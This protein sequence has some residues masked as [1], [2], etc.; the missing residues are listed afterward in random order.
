MR[1]MA[2]MIILIMMT[3]T[4]AGCF[5]EDVDPYKDKIDQLETD[6]AILESENN[7]LLE[8]VNALES[9]I[10]TLHLEQQLLEAE[11]NSSEIQIENLE[12]E[13]QLLESEKNFFEAKIENLEA[14]KQLLESEKNSS[15]IQIENLEAE[16]QLLALQIVNL[17]A[18]ITN[19]TDQIL[20]LEVDIEALSIELENSWAEGF[21]AGY[22]QAGDGVS[23]LDVIIER[24]SLKCGV[25]DSQRGMGFMDSNGVRSG[26]DISYCRA[27]AAAIGLDPD[28]DIEYVDVTAS[29]RF[30]TLE[31][32]TIDVLIRTT[33]RTTSRDAGLNVDF[34][35]TNF[36]DGIA[37]MVSEDYNYGSINTLSGITICV[38]NG[39]SIE[40]LIN[41][42]FSS[43]G[44]S[45]SVVDITNPTDATNKF[46]Q[47]QC[48][49]L[50][51]DRSSLAA[52]W[53]DETD[54]STE[55]WWSWITPEV[56]S[57]E[58]LSAA[59]R[60]YDSE[61]K[62]IVEWVWHGMVTAEELGIDS[63]NYQNA[64]TTNINIQR[65]LN[66]DLGLGTENNPLSD[67]WMQDVLE[68]VGNY[69]EAYSDAF[70]AGNIQAL[71]GT[72]QWGDCAIFRQGS[73][74]DLVSGGGMMYAPSIR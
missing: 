28:T 9:E 27:I 49:A 36:Y 62:D 7:N 63:S 40:A 26:L 21:L 44:M 1:I 42:Y 65:L 50:V 13:K 8:Q 52:K 20:A 29:N 17:T 60:D 14:E 67:T 41:D 47:G 10:L 23:T 30:S 35:A 68:H 57:K 4:L 31:S 3:S 22:S 19:L 34:A 53:L 15:E 56:I 64:D 70:C 59:V 54:S 74:N 55:V 16:K 37:L 51:G 72:P 69:G 5:G 25:K 61:W 58:P 73:L 43:Q 24:G 71:T 48:D 32:G 11:K 12:A 39:Y 18:E 38:A 46:N 2:P 6:N 66:H 45:Y 33:T